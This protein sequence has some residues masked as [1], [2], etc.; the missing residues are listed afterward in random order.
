MVGPTGPPLHSVLPHACSG[1][2]QRD[3]GEA[4]R[5]AIGTNTEE[6]TEPKEGEGMMMMMGM[7]V[8][9]GCCHDDVIY[10][11]G[12]GVHA[13]GIMTSS[14][15]DDVITHIDYLISQTDVCISQIHYPTKC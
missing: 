3:G 10:G 7:M 2:M 4:E 13:V 1:R 14:L 6:Q 15:N 9:G 11:R 8:I 12:D 5:A